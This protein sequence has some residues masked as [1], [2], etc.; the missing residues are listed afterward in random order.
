MNKAKVI[1]ILIFLM[2]VNAFAFD[3]FDIIDPEGKS[4]KLQRAKTILKGAGDIFSSG[5]E[6]DYQTEFKMGESLA[7]EGLKRY[8]MPVKSDKLQKYV[9]L[10][11][12]ALSRNSD[13]PDISY[14]FVVVNCNIYNA[15]SCPGGIIFISSALIKLMDN[16]SE[17]AG[18]LAHEIAHV[19]YK[20]ALQALKR[21]KFIEGVGQIATA[22][23]QDEKRKKYMNRISG[24]QKI[25][26][27]NG[28]DQNMEYEADIS[29]I[30][31]TYRTGYDPKGFINVLKKLRKKESHAN[32]S[33]SWFST[34]PPLS[35]RINRLNEKILAYSDSS[36]M[37]RLNKRF[38]R[39]KKLF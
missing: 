34:H 21:S 5:S 27:D 7:L 38:L 13:R 1:F 2:S 19:G 28:L 24:L 6:V 15:F 16:E 9:N 20:H 12:N 8:G 23:S 25:L 32:K 39:Y 35:Q 29:A 22:N 11:G 31:T 4:E 3:L 30:E 10:I 17:I 14:Y 26:F 37:A 33:G 36:D 18:V